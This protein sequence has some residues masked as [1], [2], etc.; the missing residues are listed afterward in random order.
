MKESVGL[1]SPV[2]LRSFGL[3]MA[4]VAAAMMAGSTL[5]AGPFHVSQMPESPWLDTE[6]CTNIV[7]VATCNELR[8]I[9]VDMQFV[10]SPTNNVQI[11][12]GCDAD[13]DGDLS[14]DETQLVFGWKCGRRFLSLP[15]EEHRT[16]DDVAAQEAGPHRLHVVAEFNARQKPV[17]FLALDNEQTCLSDFAFQSHDWSGVKSWNICKVT[18]RGL[19]EA[20]EDISVDAASA[21]FYITVR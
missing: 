10:G 9:D 20:F 1:R 21:R 2:G 12:F 11:A 15:F 6:V 5:A 3:G 19:N 4:V 17:S 7:L 8:K 13:G 14:D 18:R 16:A